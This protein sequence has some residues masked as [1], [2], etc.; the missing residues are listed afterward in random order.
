MTGVISGFSQYINYLLQCRV[1]H[2]FPPWHR[3]LLFDICPRA[4]KGLGQFLLPIC[5]HF[6]N[7]FSGWTSLPCPP[8]CVAV[9]P[10]LQD[11]PEERDGQSTGGKSAQSDGGVQTQ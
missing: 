2:I 11:L 6:P 8:V 4:D 1:V 3:G 7:L 5:C 9:L 10:R